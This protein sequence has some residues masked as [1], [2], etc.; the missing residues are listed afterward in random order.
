MKLW[1]TVLA[2]A[3]LAPFAIAQQQFPTDAKT[4]RAI[5]AKEMTPEELRSQIDKHSKTLVVDVRDADEFQKET[6][7]GAVNI[8]LEQLSGKLKTIPKDTTLVFTCNTGRRSSQAAK[9]AE[10][11][12]FKTSMFCPLRDWKE[13]G[14]PTE[15]GK[16]KS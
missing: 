12:G 8:P 4:G 5:G 2:L 14:N 6:I 3:A 10:Q 9:L 7:K 13:K 15:A 11:A 16:A 1:I